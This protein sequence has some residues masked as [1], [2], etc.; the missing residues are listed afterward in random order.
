MAKQS[1]AIQSCPAEKP[2]GY[3]K[4]KEKA[5]LGSK[6]DLGCLALEVVF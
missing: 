2:K 5:I 1:E 3:H 6:G 4:Q